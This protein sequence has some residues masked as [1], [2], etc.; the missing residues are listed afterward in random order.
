MSP[1]YVVD[2]NVLIAASAAD[3]THPAD[4]DA[5]PR[6]PEW[7]KKVWEWLDNFQASDSFL[8]L[9][10]DQEIQS[11]YE[12]K[13]GFNDFGIQ[14]VMHKWSTSAVEP[15][16]LEADGHSY[17]TLPVP[18]AAAMHDLADHKMAAA[19]YVA[20]NTVGPCPIAFAG[21]TDWHGWE[22]ILA[23][24]GIALEPVIEDWSRAKYLEKLAR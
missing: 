12:N 13:L 3:P 22:S 10:R 21:D 7:R 2:T 24:H 18:V 4:I 17:K 19:A 6:E 8:V 23:A 16:D 14:V 11:E 15:V 9:D 20:A 1:R 5:T